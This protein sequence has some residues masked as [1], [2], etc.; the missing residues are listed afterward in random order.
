MEVTFGEHAGKSVEHLVVKRPDLLAQ[1]A[2]GQLLRVQQHAKDLVARFDAKPITC[3]CFGTA[4]GQHATRG[5]V[6]PG[7]TGPAWWCDTCTAHDLDTDPSNLVSIKTYVG[8]VGY[9]KAN[10][11]AS[12]VPCQTLV[13]LFAEAKGLPKRAREPQVQDFFG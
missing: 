13:K 5:V 11:G 4:C 2:N 1:S 9:A 8:A 12:R 10:C 3:G 7:L 6:I